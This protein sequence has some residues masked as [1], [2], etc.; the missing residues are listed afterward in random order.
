MTVYFMD[1]SAIGKRYM[2]ETGSAWITM[3]TAAAAEG[4]ATDN[5]LLH[6]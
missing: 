2:L 6:P 1:S 4:F 3:L 5:P